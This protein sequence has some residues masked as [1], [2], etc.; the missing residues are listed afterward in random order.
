MADWP[1]QLMRHCP[2][3]GAEEPQPPAHS[4]SPV[5]SGRKGKP[6][7][8]SGPLPCPLPHPCTETHNP[9]EAY[10]L[11]YHV[12]PHTYTAPTHATLEPLGALSQ[13]RL[14]TILHSSSSFFLS[15]TLLLTHRPPLPPL[16]LQCAEVLS[17]PK[18]AASPLSLD[19]SLHILLVSLGQIPLI[20]F[21]LYL[22][23]YVL[24]YPIILHMNY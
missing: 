13:L 6:A 18:T 24:H 21:Q 1:S 15:P 8:N 17:C 16:P 11:S 14:A 4:K 20:L 10:T 22:Q 23:K 9:T 2:F 7:I 3:P 19:L 12:H 5:R